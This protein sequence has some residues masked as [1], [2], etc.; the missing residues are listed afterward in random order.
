M[1]KGDIVRLKEGQSWTEDDA[2]R[3]GYN[4]PSDVPELLEVADT[5]FQIV[6]CLPRAVFTMV[7]HSGFYCLQDDFEIAIPAGEPDVNKLMEESKQL[8]LMTIGF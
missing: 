6:C 5:G 7:D 2:E 8:E 4:S 1:K 3:M